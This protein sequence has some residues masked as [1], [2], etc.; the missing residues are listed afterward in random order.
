MCVFCVFFR[1][2]HAAHSTPT[3]LS[4]GVIYERKCVKF[5]YTI[6]HSHFLRPRVHDGKKDG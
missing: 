3:D 1:S 5:Y 6:S 2:I 4:N